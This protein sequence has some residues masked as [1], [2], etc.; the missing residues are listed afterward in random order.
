MTNT[1]KLAARNV[2]R[3]RRRSLTTIMAM[4]LGMT[5]IL[6]FGGYRQ[7]ISYG[8]LTAY[9]QR[10]GHLQVQHRD[11]Y[12]YG[13][14]NPTA[15]GMDDYKVL[16]DRLRSDPVL[17]PMLNE[18]TPVLQFNGIGGNFARGVSRTVLASGVVPEDQNVMRLWNEF[19][20]S[21][22]AKPVA[23]TGAV[24]NA[25]VIGTGLARTLQLCGPLH[26]VNCIDAA[27]PVA[28]D[29]ASAPAMPD[30]L[31]ALVLP[32]GSGGKAAAASTAINTQ[33]ELLVANP[34]GAP[35]IAALTAIKAEDVGVKEIDDV[36]MSMRLSQAQTLLYGRSPP[37]VTAVQIQLHHTADMPAA[38]ARIQEILG[39]DLRFADFEVLDFRELNP[40]FG[41]INAMFGAVFA[42]VSLLISVIVLFT[43]SNTMSMVVLERTSEIGTLRAI[44]QRR[45]GIRGLFLCEGMLMG[46][47]SAAVGTTLA[48]LLAAAINH[49]GLSWMPPG[50]V[51]PVRVVVRLWGEGRLILSAALGLL[52]VAA[53]SAWLPA[54][55]GARLNIVD[56][57][58]HV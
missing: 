55:R 17:T 29:A 20:T 21:S 22:A 19:G 24:E 48:L 2:L 14:G 42:S 50:R 34:N 49:S 47:I 5:A 45:G 18:V 13:S 32:E 46:A 39:G 52:F 12:L 37:R 33:V 51:D 40:S 23:L 26:V 4:V 57:L 58:R 27:P 6:L 41:Q 1:L 10:G 44:G 43:V 38:Q 30:D 15:Y 35:N 31:A 36:F 7:S 11:Y 3:N 9:V 28:A 53:L 56:A 8:L 54:K 16:I 25:T